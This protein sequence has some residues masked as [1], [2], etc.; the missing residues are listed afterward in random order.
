MRVLTGAA[1][2]G[3]A[4]ALAIAGCASSVTGGT[5][6]ASPSPAASRFPSAALS[7][8]PTV[9]G[10]K[11]GSFSLPKSACDLADPAAVERLSGR[12]PVA[13]RVVTL[14]A[15]KREQTF[16]S[17]AFTAG[18]VPVGALTVGL[19]DGGPGVSAGQE[20]DDSVSASKY[21]TS[22]A[23]DVPDVGDAARYGTTPSLAGITYATIW[24]VQVR[25]TQVLDLSITSA[26]KTPDTAKDPLIAL[27]R[28]TLARL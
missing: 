17:C 1:A 4:G 3:L 9:T 25:G 12:S 27:A 18:F 23:Q 20:L 2:A 26:A 11:P 8:T 7:G 14:S 19:R 24:V 10:T 21:G 28:S 15:P 16:L 13:P 6:P 5:P 22:A